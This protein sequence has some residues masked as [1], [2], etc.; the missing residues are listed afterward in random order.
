[1]AWTA[2]KTWT[3]GATLTAAEL[4]EQLRDNLNETMNALAVGGVEVGEEGTYFT[5]ESENKLVAR[6]PETYRINTIESTSST[7][8]TDLTTVGPEVTIET[9][10]SAFVFF[11]TGLEN[12]NDDNG[13][14]ASIAVSGDTTIAATDERSLSCDGI[15][16]IGSGNLGDNR[17]QFGKA[18]FF[19]VN[20]GINT[21][22]MK[23]R[24]GAGRGYFRHRV[25]GVFPF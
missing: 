7:S 14:F 18:I 21:F 6:R 8:Y 11:S 20:P 13:T 22:T 25:I 16:G 4:N 3:A 1:M 15:F 23:Y 9:G 5:V 17:V 24:V 2:P 19:Q 10:P 12:S